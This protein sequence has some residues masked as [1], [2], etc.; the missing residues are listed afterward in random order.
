[1]ATLKWWSAP[2]V[3]SKVYNSLE[4]K[5]ISLPVMSYLIPTNKIK[6]LKSYSK[7][8]YNSTWMNRWSK[9]KVLEAQ[10]NLKTGFLEDA[11][12]I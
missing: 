3:W 4:N 9:K 6:N 1:M 2:Q 7:I 12:I 5:W 10:T 11:R 8:N